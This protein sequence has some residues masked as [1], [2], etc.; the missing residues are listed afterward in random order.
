MGRKSL[1]DAASSVSSGHTSCRR[2]EQQGSARLRQACVCGLVCIYDSVDRVK[3]AIAEVNIVTR[4]DS[5]QAAERRI[6]AANPRQLSHEDKMELTDHSSA[7]PDA[8]IGDV[9]NFVP[10]DLPAQIL[11][12]EAPAEECGDPRATFPRVVLVAP[13]GV[14]VCHEWRLRRAPAQR[15]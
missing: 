13:E 2:P 7:G 11:R 12:E 9:H 8:P 4:V 5:S 15:S 3:D 6:P 1:G 10:R 14:V